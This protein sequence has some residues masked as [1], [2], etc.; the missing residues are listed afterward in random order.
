MLPIVVWDLTVL[1]KYRS[2]LYGQLLASWRIYRR[3][4]S[5]RRFQWPEIRQ[6]L[7]FGDVWWWCSLLV[8][9][10][11]VWLTPGHPL[12]HDGGKFWVCY[13]LLIKDF[14]PSSFVG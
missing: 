11:G 5:G 6:P 7:L 1:V 8:F 13:V 4:W 3:N 12:K 2:E 14:D 10:G 9:G